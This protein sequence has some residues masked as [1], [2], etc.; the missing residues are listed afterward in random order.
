MSILPYGGILTQCINAG[1]RTKL[2]GFARQIIASEPQ[3]WFDVVCMTQTEG[4][5]E[6]PFRAHLRERHGWEEANLEAAEEANPERH[7]SQVHTLAHQGDVDHPEGELVVA[8]RGVRYQ[9]PPPAI[10]EALGGFSEVRDKLPPRPK[11][12]RRKRSGPRARGK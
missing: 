9:P 1:P 6:D 5:V 3:A 4:P 2:T 8:A 7:W 10:R 12:S 11:R